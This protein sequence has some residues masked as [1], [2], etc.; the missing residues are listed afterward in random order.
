[1]NSLSNGSSSRRMNPLNCWYYESDLML[2][3]CENLPCWRPSSTAASE[4][5]FPHPHR[6]VIIHLLQYCPPSPLTSPP[7]VPSSSS[8]PGSFPASA[9]CCDVNIANTRD[10]TPLWYAACI[11]RDRF[12]CVLLLALGADPTEVW[13]CVYTARDSGCWAMEKAGLLKELLSFK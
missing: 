1:M 7:S 6:N 13:S 12:L 3:A 10:R 2:E 11:A 9:Y 5:Y 4:R 8:S